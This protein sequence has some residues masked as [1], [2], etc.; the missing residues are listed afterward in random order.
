MKYL[1]LVASAIAVASLVG[2]ADQNPA[3]NPNAPAIS[4]APLVLK[5]WEGTDNAVQFAN[6]RPL[7]FATDATA[8][9]LQCAGHA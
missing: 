7:Q 5:V 3:T 6:A 9:G 2:C 4:P 1:G 8:A